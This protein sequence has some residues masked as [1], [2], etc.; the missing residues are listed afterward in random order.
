MLEAVGVIDV[1]KS[2]CFKF[3]RCRT[4]AVGLLICTCMV[5]DVAAQ[6]FSPE[7]DLVLVRRVIDTRYFTFG[8]DDT[9]SFS[10]ESPPGATVNWAKIENRNSLALENLIRSDITRE[11]QVRDNDSIQ[12]IVLRE[13]GFG[14]KNSKSAYAAVEEKILQKNG[15]S[16]PEDLRAGTRLIIPA[17]PPIAPTQPSSYNIRNQIPKT[18]IYA[19]LPKVASGEA[20]N[21]NGL[22]FTTVPKYSDSL[23][24]GAPLAMQYL[25]IPKSLVEQERLQIGDGG[26]AFEVH[27]ESVTARM[28]AAEATSQSQSFLTSSDR[29]FLVSQLSATPKQAP[30]LIILDD[31]WPN[32]EAYKDSIKFLTEAF[33][34]I[35]KKFKYP[36]G[37]NVRSLAA[38]NSTSFPKE[39]FHARA[40]ADSLTPLTS[41][42]ASEN[43]E[44]RRVRVV[45]LPITAAQNYSSSVLEDI[46]TLRL[47]D[48]LMASGRGDDPPPQSEVA[49]FREKAKE[50]V[51][52]LSKHIGVSEV[53]TDKA[54]IESVL[55]L[56]DLYTRA[57]G[58]TYVAN[59]SWT[60]S[61]L[62]N[63]YADVRFNMGLLV[64]AAG[65]S[66][67]ESCSACRPH[68][69]YKPDCSCA[70]NV[71][72]E[73]RMVCSQGCRWSST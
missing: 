7:K 64:S 46:I 42:D 52:R 30:V 6:T 41:L 11:S 47:I 49:K 5:M 24:R 19:N 26:E 61:K 9:K 20:V 72:A 40:I 3:I 60:T 13:Y 44:H 37:R 2:D 16:R 69:A 28:G 45:Y 39:K 58:N 21:S 50:I 8:A 71:A 55:W 51:S 68:L 14:Q 10:P 43:W 25:W 73:E 56:A 62:K 22:N 65:N 33:T 63:R 31:G 35:E 70:D 67:G 32:N 12:S 59:F 57:T 27:A 34:A 17:L 54:V 29:D 53:T 4:R 1:T 48:D 23:R 18:S 15:L 66:S 38:S 36:F